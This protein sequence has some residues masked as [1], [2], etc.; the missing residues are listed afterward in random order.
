LAHML[1]D[2]ALSIITASYLHEIN[3]S[4]GRSLCKVASEPLPDQSVPSSTRG[5]HPEL[6]DG[7]AFLLGAV[8]QEP[9]ALVITTQPSSY[10]GRK[11]RVLIATTP[12]QCE[13]RRHKD[14]TML[15][16]LHASLGEIHVLQFHESPVSNS[17]ESPDSKPHF[18]SFHCFRLRVMEY[19]WPYLRDEFI[20]KR[21]AKVFCRTA[22]AMRKSSRKRRHFG[23]L[24]KPELTRD[25]DSLVRLLESEAPSSA[26]TKVA[27]KIL[28]HLRE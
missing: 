12:Q 9:F 20:T 28:E 14:L 13:T 3:F 6:V 25:I 1:N 10:G 19:V 11:L 23:H 15:R 18:P 16:E 17:S 7:I 5:A 2:L 22:E 4:H 26:Q 24:L 8:S 27:F 21:R